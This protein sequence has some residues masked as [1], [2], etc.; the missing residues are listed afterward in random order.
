MTYPFTTGF[1]KGSATSKAAADSLQSRDAVAFAVLQALYVVGAHGYIV[2]EA[3]PI[4]EHALGRDF[5]RS[6]VAARFTEL[7]EMGYIEETSATRQ[8]P[9]GRQ[10]AVHKISIKGR[11]AVLNA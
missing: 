8:T 9:R 4:V 2:D 3:K 7:K 11:D 10:A 6:T 5:D 1:A